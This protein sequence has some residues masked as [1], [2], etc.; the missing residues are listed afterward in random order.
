MSF[1]LGL[2]PQSKYGLI[3]KNA[4]VPNTKRTVLKKAALGFEDELNDDDDDN[5]NTPGNGSNNRYE[6]QKVNASLLQ[7]ADA[8]AKAMDNMS[9]KDVDMYDY[10]GFLEQKEQSSGSHD[11]GSCRSYEK[12]TASNAT[13]K[14]APAAS[15]VHSLKSAAVIRE[16][17]KD[18]QFERKLLKERKAEEDKEREETGT[19][20]EVK[21]VTSAYKKKLMEQT[22]W[23]EE[24]KIMREVERRTTAGAGGA[25][26]S[27]FYS[28]L[29]TKNVAMGSSIED[30]A[31]SAYTS[32]SK[33]QTSLLS[34]EEG[35]Y[36]SGS[37]RQ[38]SLLSSEEG[39][40][41]DASDPNTG[42]CVGDAVTSSSPS[43]SSSDVSRRSVEYRGQNTVTPADTHTRSSTSGPYLP[44][45]DPIP[46]NVHGEMADS[47]QKASVIMSARERYLKRA[48]VE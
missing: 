11:S 10:D 23:E 5:D 13:T 3:K 7:K 22:R 43:T 9:G 37:K 35:A 21:F 38:T 15:Y 19:V 1:K 32:G 26:M 20:N 4:A 31:I 48:R 29:L 24:D 47:A 17:E 6:I 2:A 39:A 18:R 28:N 34:S 16:K 14:P 30:S 40:G 12:E 41:T 44:S 36:T 45:S 8:T 25:G 42:G 33:R 46:A 27:G